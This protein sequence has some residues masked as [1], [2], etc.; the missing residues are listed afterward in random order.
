MRFWRE[1]RGA[2]AL[3]LAALTACPPAHGLVSLNDGHDKIYVTGST[4]VG[5]DSN[6]FANSA[7]RSSAVYSTSLQAEY[8]RRAGWIGVNG[9]MS[10]TSSHFGS[11]DGQDFVNPTFGLEFTKQ[12]GRTTGALTASASRESRADADVNTRS[13]YWI[14]PVGLNFKYPIVSTYTMAGAF[15]Y[16]SQRYVNDTVFASLATYHGSLDLFHTIGSERDIFAGYRY[17]YSETTHETSSIDHAWSLGLNGKLIR[18]V[19]GSV[20][21]GYQTR[22]IETILGSQ[23]LD[24]WTASGTATYALSKK[25]SLTGTLAK[26]FATTATDASVDSTTASLDLRYTYSAHWSATGS[27]SLGDNAFLGEGG[28]IDYIRGGPPP[29]GPNR[30]DNFLTAGASLNYSLN[31]H[32]KAALSYSWFKNWSSLTIADFVRSSWTLSFSSRW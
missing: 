24:S 2:L 9:N 7:E 6:V 30:H 16:S 32:F 18:G 4:S 19:N 13:T 17:R 21:V 25:T 10:V 3:L 1:F 14:V 8:T 26:D 29:V 28:R 23:S 15:G 22:I 5:F 31:E 11:V 12:S 27:V 20:R